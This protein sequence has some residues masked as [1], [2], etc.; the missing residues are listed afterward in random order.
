MIATLPVTRPRFRTYVAGP[1]W[2][3]AALP[4]GVTR[5]ASLTDAIDRSARP[6]CA[7]RARR[8]A[9]GSNERGPGSARS[10]TSDPSPGTAGSPRWMTSTGPM[11]RGASA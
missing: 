7:S 10:G 6:S 5:L 11:S 2:D 1:G 3:G 4:T 9:V 8:A